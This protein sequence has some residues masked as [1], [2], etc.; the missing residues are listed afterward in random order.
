MLSSRQGIVRE[1][2]VELA[3]EYKHFEEARLVEKVPILGRFLLTIGA[4]QKKD[5]LLGN[6]VKSSETEEDVA[7]LLKTLNSNVNIPA[8][9]L[10]T[11]I[12]VLT[13][14]LDENT[15]LQNLNALIEKNILNNP[16]LKNQDGLKKPFVNLI[17]KLNALEA[18]KYVKVETDQLDALNAKYK[19]LEKNSAATTAKLN[20]ELKAAQS[21]L[22]KA[23][24]SLT[25][26]SKEN[27]EAKKDKQTLTSQIQSLNAAL[28]EL[29]AKSTA[30]TEA[31]SNTQN[32]LQT[33]I[34]VLKN[35][36]TAKEKALNETLST[37]Q[38]KIK[39]LSDDIHSKQQS[40]ETLKTQLA[41]KEKALNEASS[42]SQAKIKSLSDEIQLKQQSIQTLEAKLAQVN[43]EADEY[44]KT[45]KDFQAQLTAK[46]AELQEKDQNIV[47]LRKEISD[48]KAK[49]EKLTKTNEAQATQ[50]SGLNLQLAGLN[51]QLG[52]R[53]QQSKAALASANA[54]ILILQGKNQKLEQAVAVNQA[55]YTEA[56]T[57]SVTQIT[58][59]EHRIKLIEAREA[60]A[61]ENA[62]ASAEKVKELEN[63]L[64]LLRAEKTKLAKDLSEAAAKKDQTITTLSANL[65]MLQKQRKEAAP[66]SIAKKDETISQLSSDL[67]A[68]QD[69]NIQLEREL[70]AAKAKLA[71]MAESSDTEVESPRPST[72]G[73]FSANGA[74]RMTTRSQKHGAGSGP[75]PKH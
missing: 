57:R 39:S 71:Q 52:E 41:A 68:F 1:A 22:A 2:V 18:E 29:K 28:A 37:S 7:A 38:A 33:E 12:Q 30:S 49:M 4:A 3:P 19:S 56:H 69:R 14:C 48:L 58:Q 42:A 9:K 62:K 67:K 43:K 13:A 61:N 27:D 75:R 32:K 17:L 66:P 47:A 36:L 11:I 74:S 15:S 65:S 55:D 20:A 60:K 35:Q 40:I 45:I 31:L 50:L 25:T 54:Q 72:N 8:G 44:L 6:L 59:L 51:L 10:K 5:H 24:A 70:A 53:E 46:I 64:N 21:E 34:D 73:M 16:D 63:M 23:Q 26:V